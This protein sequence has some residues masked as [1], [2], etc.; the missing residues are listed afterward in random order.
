MSEFF[1]RVIDDVDEK[2]ERLIQA[3]EELTGEE[4]VRV[5]NMDTGEYDYTPVWVASPSIIESALYEDCDQVSLID[6]VQYLSED[7]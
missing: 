7:I 1:E 3:H 4:I 5:Q 2:R 6:E